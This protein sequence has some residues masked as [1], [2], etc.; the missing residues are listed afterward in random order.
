MA[1][2]LGQDY[3]DVR[4]TVGIPVRIPVMAWTAHCC[5]FDSE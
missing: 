1:A 3:G 5:G 4:I 2:F